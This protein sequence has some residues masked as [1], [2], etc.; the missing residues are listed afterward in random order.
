M[1]VLAAVDT[2]RP[3]LWEARTNQEVDVLVPLAHLRDHAHQEVDTLAIHQPAEHDDR[4]WKN[5]R[6]IKLAADT[7][8]CAFPIQ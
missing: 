5:E 6:A 2:S 4:H 3:H 7:F 1:P 8:S